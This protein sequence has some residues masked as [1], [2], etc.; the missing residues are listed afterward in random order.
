MAFSEIFTQVGLAFGVIVT[1]V[2]L[3]SGAAMIVA[4]FIPS[5]E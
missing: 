4:P 3:V 5:A 2:L 1:S